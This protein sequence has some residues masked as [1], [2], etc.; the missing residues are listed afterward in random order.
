[1]TKLEILQ[2]DYNTLSRTVVPR[3][4]ILGR[5]W[6]T[7]KDYFASRSLDVFITKLRKLFAEDPHI[8]IV[9]KRGTGLILMVNN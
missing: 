5:F 9:T 2:A 4:T 8:E 6:N 7:D 3:E 1:M